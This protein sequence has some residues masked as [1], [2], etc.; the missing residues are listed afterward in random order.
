M[1]TVVWWKKTS[2]QQKPGPDSEYMKKVVEL[3][4]SV[5]HE[6]DELRDLVEDLRCALIKEEQQSG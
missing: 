5:L 3:T 6:S 2:S 4:E 1:I